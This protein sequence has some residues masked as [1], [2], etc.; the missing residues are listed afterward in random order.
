MGGNKLY[1]LK[2]LYYF[3]LITGVMSKHVQTQVIGFF[4]NKK[5]LLKFASNGTLTH[6]FNKYI[7]IRPEV[8]LFDKLHKSAVSCVA[9]QL[10]SSYNGTSF[11]LQLTLSPHEYKMQ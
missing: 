10:I 8:P 1:Y 4:K 7:I 5:T 6:G 11:K 3:L 9:L 2:F